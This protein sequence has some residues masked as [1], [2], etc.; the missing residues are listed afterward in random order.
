[1][2]YLSFLFLQAWHMSY[3][4][5]VSVLVNNK[6]YY[7]ELPPMFKMKLKVTWQK[8]NVKPYLFRLSVKSKCFLEG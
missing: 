5:T 8:D 6:E 3:I 1:M 2:S 7:R 4:L